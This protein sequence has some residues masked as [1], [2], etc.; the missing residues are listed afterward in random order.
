MRSH[1]EKR[2]QETVEATHF[3]DANVHTMEIGFNDNGITTFH[4]F[5]KVL[6]LKF[7]NVDADHAIR[8]SK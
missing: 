2:K 8:R 6:I 1:A 5:N 4:S 3:K 7:T